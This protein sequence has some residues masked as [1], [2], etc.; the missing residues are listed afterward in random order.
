[1]IKLIAL[2]LD[3]TTLNREGQLSPKT[4]KVIEAAI[5]RGTEVVIATGRVLSAL[6]ED[7]LT[8]KGLHYA[9]TS[10]GAN[11]VDMKSDQS[12]YTNL[13][14][15][16]IVE[17]I[18][19]TLKKYEFMTE[20]FTNGNAY[21]EEAVYNE[22][23]KNGSP[24]HNTSY[25]L[26]TREPVAGLFE[27]ILAH[28][29]TIENINL[30]FENPKDRIMMKDVLTHLA[31]IAVTSSFNYNLEIC[32][33]GV[34]KAD[35]LKWL[36]N[37]LNLTSNEV[38]ACGDSDNDIEMLKYAGLSIAV[39]NANERVKKVAGCIAPANDE[40]GVAEAIERLILSE[41]NY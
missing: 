36:C 3:G 24:F 15:E 22:I 34:S 6:P 29:K 25:L 12:I 2:D 27:Y 5:A 32:G 28:R 33:S 7:V 31:G 19:K 38:M 11:T 26:T 16:K 17:H 1:M 39:E 20:V 23:R 13:I 4:K 8:M 9:I 35:A 10:N 30:N 37:M 21:I 14:D 40:N 18:I 41:K